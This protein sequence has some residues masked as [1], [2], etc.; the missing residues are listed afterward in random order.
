MSAPVVEVDGL[1]IAY[2]A[3]RADVPVVRG[4]S[5]A[6]E[7]GCTLGLV[8]ESG[9]GKSTVAAALLGHLRRGS[10]ITAGTVALH[11]EDVFAAA[12]DG[13]ARC[14]AGPSRWSRRTPGRC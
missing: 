1:G 9:S 8:G 12:R 11:G 5:F 7:P 6:V 13:C 10:R 3:G 14:A 4:V 2:R